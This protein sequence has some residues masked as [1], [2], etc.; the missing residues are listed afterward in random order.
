MNYLKSIWPTL[1]D[2]RV[3]F[4]RNKHWTKSGP[5]RTH[6]HLTAAQQKIKD[7]TGVDVTRL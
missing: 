6:N 2:G 7:M 3:S 1:G 5:G 4:P